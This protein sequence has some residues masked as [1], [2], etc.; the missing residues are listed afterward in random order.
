MSHSKLPLRQVIKSVLASMLGV[1][2]R[3]NQ[4]QDFTKGHFSVY[5]IV[6]IV[7]VIGLI[8]LLKTLVFFV[9][10]SQS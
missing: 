10:K 5:I 1:Q 6:S 9:V 8:F 4:L 3:K 2:S 7:F